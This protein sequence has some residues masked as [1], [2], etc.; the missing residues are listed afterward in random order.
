MGGRQKVL[1]V[2]VGVLLVVLFVGVVGV[3]RQEG[4]DP[5]G[6]HSLVELLGRVGGGAGAVD[7]DSV[8]AGCAE[9]PGRLAV[10]GDCAVRVAD[11]GGLRLLILRSP[12][13]FAVEAPAPG[14]A[15]FTLTDTVTP[16]EDGTDAVARIA[17]DRPSIVML[18]CPTGCVVT[19]SRQ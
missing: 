1:V 6:R 19:V 3:G 7:P 11:P 4:G 9:A 5:V 8:Q 18:R 14:G 2:G 16:A 12:T 15:D 17:V 13:G 10:V